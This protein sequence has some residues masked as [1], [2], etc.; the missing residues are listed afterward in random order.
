MRVTL[1]P[2]LVLVGSPGLLRVI[3][4]PRFILVGGLEP[5]K[6]VSETCAEL[7]A[8]MRR[9]ACRLWVTTVPHII[10]LGGTRAAA[11][12][13]VG[14]L[15]GAHDDAGG[16][17]DVHGRRVGAEGLQHRAL[18]GLQQVLQVPHLQPQHRAQGLGL[19]FRLGP[20][21]A[22][23]APQKYLLSVTLIFR[24]T[25]ATDSSMLRIVMVL[26]TYIVYFQLAWCE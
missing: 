14:L 4:A 18:A 21:A 2:H 7:D 8:C 5:V 26:G 6:R 19:G 24:V 3:L 16:E 22:A 20:G 10:P 12:Q 11:H 1:Q 9:H 13:G 25:T 23:A 17:A 15:D